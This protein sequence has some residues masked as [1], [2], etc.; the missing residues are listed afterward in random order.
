M[1][2]ETLKQLANHAGG[3]F[4]PIMANVHIYASPTGNRAQVGN[5]RYW[6]DVP[7]NL[8][9]MTV[10]AERLAAAASACGQMPSIT[11]GASQVSVTS[12]RVRA[13]IG[14]EASPYNRVD[15]DPRNTVAV[16]GVGAILLALAKFSATDASRPWATSICL[17]GDY[18][19]STNNVIVAR[20]PLPAT[21][22]RSV[23]IPSLAVD[24]V[25]ERGEVID[26][27]HTDNAVTFYY[28]DDSWVKTLLIAGEWPTKTVDNYIAGM[29]QGIW[30]NV[31]P[32]LGD[33]LSTAAKLCDERNPIVQ[34]E[35]DGI[36]LLDKTF[37]ADDLGPLPEDGRV[38]AKMANL[39]FNVATEVQWHNP[40]RD[41]HGF[42][43]GKLTGVLAGTK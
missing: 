20:H 21:V 33:M 43:A 30:E 10:N 39:V 16:P 19:Y 13:R 40:K 32:S 8:P 38:S 23:N 18:A 27:G 42:R 9:A 3:T 31:N 37:E 25:V 4:L 7:T 11:V 12:G 6:V 22:A 29:E 28:A 26:V 14:V 17:C 5:G 15:P 34:F 36:A 1:N 35:K 24:A 2:I 41:A